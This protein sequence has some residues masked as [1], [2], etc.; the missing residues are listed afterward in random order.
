MAADVIDISRRYKGKRPDAGFPA[1]GPSAKP[2]FVRKAHA[3]SSEDLAESIS[4]VI[5]RLEHD[6]KDDAR[7]LRG[8]VEGHV[9]SIASGKQDELSGMGLLFEIP[10]SKVRI[11]LADGESKKPGAEKKITAIVDAC[12][13][14]AKSDLAA[15]KEAQSAMEKKGSLAGAQLDGIAPILDR[16]T[17]W[18]YFQTT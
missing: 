3:Q 7:H 6:L 18:R 11:E 10:E 12:V 5:A 15:L 17:Y 9:R 1:K 8:H 13:K 14:A 16:G 2:F 4:A